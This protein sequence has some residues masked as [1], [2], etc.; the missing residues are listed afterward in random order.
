[1]MSQHIPYIVNGLFKKL[2]VEESTRHK[3]VKNRGTTFPTR[4]HVHPAEISLRCPPEEA[5]DLWLPTVS[6]EDYDQTVW[7]RNL[8]RVFTG[9]TSKTIGNAVPRLK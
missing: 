6:C 8:I 4:Q 9:R 3:C 2:A 5:F 7:M 1:M